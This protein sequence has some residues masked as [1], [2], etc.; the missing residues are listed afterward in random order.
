M[1]TAPDSKSLCL[2]CANGFRTAPAVCLVDKQLPPAGLNARY[3]RLCILN[4]QRYS[5]GSVRNKFIDPA[6][7]ITLGTPLTPYGPGIT[8]KDNLEIE[9][10]YRQRRAENYVPECTHEEVEIEDTGAVGTRDAI[11]EFRAKSI[12]HSDV[13]S[14]QCIQSWQVKVKVVCDTTC[15]MYMLQGSTV[16]NP[17]QALKQLDTS[18]VRLRCCL[19]CLKYSRLYSDCLVLREDELATIFLSSQ[20]D[21]PGVYRT[22]LKI[23]CD[24]YHQLRTSV[25]GQREKQRVEKQSA[26][27]TRSK[28]A[29]YTAI[30]ERPH[31][32]FQSHTC[33]F[34]P[35]GSRA[36]LELVLNFQARTAKEYVAIARS[37]M[38]ETLIEY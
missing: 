17:Q 30:A 20:S 36:R 11:A 35:I 25:A 29:R 34:I 26:R 12:Y 31:K 28:R 8:D 9:I 33:V 23:R 37:C 2:F 1:T 18:I 10:A 21:A 22:P 24:L 19:S 14:Q 32:L 5:R 13:L 3:H 38:L 15:N 6:T 27:S 4:Y 7:N 16:F